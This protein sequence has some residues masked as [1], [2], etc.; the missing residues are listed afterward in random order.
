M[1]I[2]NRVKKHSFFCN[3][4]YI[5]FVSFYFGIFKKILFTILERERESEWGEGKRE[6]DRESPGDSR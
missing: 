2:I 4:S 3:E 6:W 5:S 1:S